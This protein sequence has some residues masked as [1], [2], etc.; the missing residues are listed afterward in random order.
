MVVSVNTD[1]E[2]QNGTGADNTV[3]FNEIRGNWETYR[4]NFTKDFTLAYDRLICLKDGQ[5]NFSCISYNNNSTHTYLYVNNNYMVTSYNEG[6]DPSNNSFSFDMNLKRGD[7]VQIR[8]G[9]GTDS[10]TYN[11]FQIKRI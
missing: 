10:L 8:G 7:E 2:T 6:S 3:L 9:Y 5:Y 1:T 4:N 11:S